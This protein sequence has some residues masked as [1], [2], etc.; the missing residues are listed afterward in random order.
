MVDVDTLEVG[1]LP[2][3]KTTYPNNKEQKGNL[4]RDS[5]DEAEL[6]WH[7]LDLKGDGEWYLARKRSLFEVTKNMPKAHTL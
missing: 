6:D 1:C 3:S 7:L 4:E 5:K 2:P